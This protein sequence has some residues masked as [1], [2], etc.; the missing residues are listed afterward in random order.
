MK[1]KDYENAIRNI[2][3]TVKKIVSENADQ[4]S[5]IIASDKL[6]DDVANALARGVQAGYAVI[7]ARLRGEVVSA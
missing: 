5:A 6:T 2:E 1:T 7:S 3:E 4:V